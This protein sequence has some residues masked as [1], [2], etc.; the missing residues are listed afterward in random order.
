[1]KFE[2]A[3]IKI[4]EKLHYDFEEKGTKE[5]ELK[6][7]RIGKIPLNKV[8]S[9]LSA[10][11]TFIRFSTKEREYLIS[12]DGMDY[13]NNYKSQE[14]QG[15][16]NQIVAFAGAILALIG[17][18]TFINDLGLI[19]TTNF[20]INYIFLGF[21]MISIAPLIKFLWRSYFW[22]MDER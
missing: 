6:K 18:Y 22:E 12:P 2:Q 16:F 1:M 10:R 5:E 13:L 4:L 17:I 3:C 7:V 11:N 9:Y 19:N 21:A 15:E 20:W 8:L 14:R